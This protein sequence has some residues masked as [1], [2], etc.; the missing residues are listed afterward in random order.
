MNPN[1]APLL[2]V[3]DLDGSLLDHHSYSWAAAKPCLN[4]LKQHNTPIMFCTSKTKPEVELLQQQMGLTEQPYICE[5]GAILATN[6]Q[7]S[8]IAR[9]SSALNYLEITRILNQLKKK[10]HFHFSGFA[11]ASLQEIIQWTG[12]SPL[13]AQFSKQRIASEPIL[14]QDST[15]QF[16]QFQQQLE[17]YQLCLIK[18]GRFWHVMNIGSNKGIA[19]SHFLQQEQQQ[20]RYWQTIGL[21]DSPNDLPLLEITDFSVIIQS[22]QSQNILLQRKDSSH[23]FHS[24]HSGPTGWCEGISFFINHLNL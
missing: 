6:Q 5:N 22:A 17:Q 2:I 7:T 9:Q 23:I 16:T 24:Q 19:L 10:Y 15:D 12:L 20:D 13:Q 21:G 1:T 3:T 14:W 8:I 11:H 4:R 18:G